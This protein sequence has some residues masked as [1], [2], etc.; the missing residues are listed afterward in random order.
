MLG[1][2]CVN[3][4]L[5]EKEEVGGETA[6]R[7]EFGWVL[8]GPRNQNSSINTVIQV[9]N[10]QT[11]IETLWELEQPPKTVSVP[12]AFPMIKSGK[13]FKVGLLWKGEERPQDNKAR[14]I[15]A[16]K[17]LVSRLKRNNTFEAYQDILMGEYKEL[18]AIEKE[19]NPEQAGYYLPHHAVV[20]QDAATTKLRVVFNASDKAGTAKSLNDVIDP[21]P[22][23][24]PDLAGLL[25]RFT[26]FKVEVQADIKKAFFRIKV[27]KQ[28]RSYL[29]FLW[30]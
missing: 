13:S 27:N 17:S 3:R 26:E 22:S 19:P 14:A 23:L 25:M 11:D 10:I 12:P 8:S 20:R 30:P 18:G 4:F 21:G 5:Q 16:V 15:A 28:D 9:A 6:W 7:T 1:A 24:L 29:R 2:D